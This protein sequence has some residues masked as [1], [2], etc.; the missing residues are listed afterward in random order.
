MLFAQ[1]FHPYAPIAHDVDRRIWEKFLDHL[2]LPNDSGG[3]EQQSKQRND[4]ITH[5]I[6]DRMGHLLTMVNATPFMTRDVYRRRRNATGSFI[7]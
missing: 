1:A 4:H 3:P 7:N 6:D 2:D 5:A